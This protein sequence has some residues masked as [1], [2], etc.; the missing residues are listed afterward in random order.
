MK[1]PMQVIKKI[2]R[3]QRDFLWGGL[4]RGKKLCWIKWK[5]VCQEKR[6]GGLGVRDV[7]AVN[8]SL[9]MKWRWRLL[10]SDDL[11]HWKEVLSAKYGSHILFTAVW[12]SNLSSIFASTWWR[13][14]CD[15]E[16]CVENK[17]WVAESLSHCLGN[18][19]L[20][21][22]WLDKWIGN[23]LLSVT[24]P[25]LFLLSIAKEAK[26][27]DLVTVEDEHIT[28]NLGWRRALFLWEEELVNNLLVSLEVVTLSSR[29]DRWRWKW[30]PV[31]FSVKSAFEVLSKEIVPGPLLSVFEAKI[32]SNIWQSPA[33]S[34]VLAFSWQLLY[35]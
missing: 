23:E 35:D 12:P 4:R 27:G 13:D 11:E 14:L 28:W 6:K 31:G 16:S 15:L 21:S 34:K 9:L 10:Q 2:T 19:A 5:V 30:D 8:L 20:T 32:I 25:R 3:I 7:K 18:G 26:I 22:F 1:M 29:E 33:P 17:N 24:F